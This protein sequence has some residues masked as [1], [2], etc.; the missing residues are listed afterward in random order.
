MGKQN[1]FSLI[2]T[3]SL[4][5]M[6]SMLIMALYNVV[7][8]IFVSRYSTIALNAVSLAF[9]LQL[10]AISFAVGTAIGVNSL[11]ARRLGSKNYDEANSAA[12]HGLFLAAFNTI[13]FVIIGLVFSKLFISLFTKNETTIS[14][15]T[16]YLTIVLCFCIGQMF[17]CM[18]EKTLQATGN[19]IIPMLGQVLGAVINIIFDPLLIFGI[20]IFPEMGVVGAAVATVFGQICSAIFLLCMLIFKKHDVKIKVKGFKF[21]K[22]TL[23]NIYV[24][25]VPA[26]IMQAIG[27]VMVSGINTIITLS[28]L[29]VEYIEAYIN[30]FGIYFKVQSFVFMPIFGLSQGVSPIIG[31]NYGAKNRKRMYKAFSLSVLIA[32]IIMACGMLLFQFGSDF[33]LTLF[34]DDELIHTLG[35]P[36]FKIIS[37]CFI[38]AAFGM[39][40]STLFQAIGKG[41]YSMLMSMGRQ[42]FV[43]LPVA[44]LL[45]KIDIQYMWYAFVIAEA[46]CL[47]IAFIFF[48][49]VKTKDFDKMV[50]NEE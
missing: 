43:L 34:T 31:Y 22:S 16:S 15:G 38:V 14:Y 26:I 17:S 2:I 28:S 21:S 35:V 6:F 8:S 9:P 10:V 5:A 12:T 44:F 24:V 7:D 25:G 33:I 41:V 1:M 19:M 39:M 46:V 27:S 11:I 23:K 48:K 37:L 36:T 13:L 4:P 47:G 42:L 30:V 49:I 29:A 20:G 18:I 32:S 50:L 45:S 3:M 40:F